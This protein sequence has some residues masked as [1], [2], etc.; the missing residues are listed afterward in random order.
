MSLSK[1]DWFYL[2]ARLCDGQL[3]NSKAKAIAIGHPCILNQIT[4]LLLSRFL[5]RA[6]WKANHYHLDTSSTVSQLFS[7]RHRLISKP[8]SVVRLLSVTEEAFP[9]RRRR[10]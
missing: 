5:C 4:P 10:L 8:Y 6:P 1:S 2:H 9:V 3:A 7:P